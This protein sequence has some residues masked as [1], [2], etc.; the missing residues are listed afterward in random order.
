MARDTFD[1]DSVQLAPGGFYHSPGDAQGT[2]MVG[3]GRNGRNKWVQLSQPE[4][5]NFLTHAATMVRTD[6]DTV[7]AA[8][9]DLAT[10]LAGARKLTT[11][12][13]LADPAL[14][15]R[16]TELLLE[17]LSRDDV[18]LM[19]SAELAEARKTAKPKAKSAA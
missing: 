8:L 18:L 7:K 9:A 11:D 2:M 3:W 1:F 15:K 5:V 4:I 16:Y 17:G 12:D 6:D 13:V 14:L 19:I 10:A